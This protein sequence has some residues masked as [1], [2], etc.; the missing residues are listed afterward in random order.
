MLRIEVWTGDKI[1]TN[2]TIL[3]LRLV[4]PVDYGAVVVVVLLL[5]ERMEYPVVDGRCGSVP[6][7]VI[8]DDIEHEILILHQ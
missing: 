2:P 1:V 4:G 6:A 7:V 5:V 3:N 8:D